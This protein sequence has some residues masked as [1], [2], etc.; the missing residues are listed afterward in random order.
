MYL[1][2]AKFANINTVLVNVRVSDMATRR[3]G[4]KYY[5]SCVE[6]LKYMKRHRII[7]FWTYV[8]S[9]IVRFCGYVLLPNK[10]RELMYRKLLR[11]ARQE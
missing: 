6:L 4:I 10:L 1:S 2:G 3:G 9:C 11:K 7:G 8:K 5:R